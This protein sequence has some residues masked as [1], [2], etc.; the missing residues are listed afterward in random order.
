VNKPL[1]EALRLHKVYQLHASLHERC[2]QVQQLA[3]NEVNNEFGALFQ[4]K[5][6][7]ELI[8]FAKEQQS[9]QL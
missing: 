6:Y 9:E 5:K 2:I 1:Q 3:T 7:K 4:E 8:Q